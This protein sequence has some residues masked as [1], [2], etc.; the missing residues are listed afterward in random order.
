MSENG[1]TVIALADGAGSK[2][3]THSAQGAECVTKTI[4]KFFCNNFDKF[5]EKKDTNGL[6]SVTGTYEDMLVDI[7]SYLDENRTAEAMQLAQ[8]LVVLSSSVIGLR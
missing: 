8:E 5:Y 7:M 6:C 2:K 3:Y 1:V 4:T